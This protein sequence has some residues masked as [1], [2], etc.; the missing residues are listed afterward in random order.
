[1]LQRKPLSRWTS[2][3]LRLW[4]NRLGRLLILVG[5]AGDTPEAWRV[6]HQ[7]RDG[8]I[9]LKE[10]ERRLRRLARKAKARPGARRAGRG[11]R[12][13]GRAGR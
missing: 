1:M 8:V 11:W 7:Y 10:A 13:Q 9:T 3:D 6:Y 12:R 2:K 4:R 5:E